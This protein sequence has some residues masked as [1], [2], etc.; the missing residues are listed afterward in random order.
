MFLSMY[1]DIANFRKQPEEVIGMFSEALQILDR[2][3]TKYM[4]DT[5]KQSIEDL[6]QENA[7]KDQVVAE[8]RNNLAEKDNTIA[9]LR[10]ELQQLSGRKS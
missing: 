3:T 4:I 7:E 9:E 6:T 10:A 5:M 2:N 8:L 1:Q